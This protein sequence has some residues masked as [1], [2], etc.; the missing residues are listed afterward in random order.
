[1]SKMKT[2]RA[3]SNL[4]SDKVRLS[5]QVE[6]SLYLNIKLICGRQ[7]WTI[8]EWLHGLILKDVLYH[9]KSQWFIEFVAENQD[10]SSQVMNQ[11]TNELNSGKSV[12]EVYRMNIADKVAGIN[13]KNKPNDEE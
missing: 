6:G 10:L 13:K 8:D 4:S 12:D 3:K 2:L 11:I 9:M 1:M 7:G 5:A